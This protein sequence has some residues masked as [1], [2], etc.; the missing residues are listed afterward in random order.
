MKPGILVAVAGAAA[1]TSVAALS[2]PRAQEG[3][4]YLRVPVN[5]VKPD[6]S[7]LSKRDAFEVL[8]KNRDFFYSMDSKCLFDPQ[9]ASFFCRSTSHFPRHGSTRETHI[10]K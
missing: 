9:L 8:L 1:V 7:G 3:A 10:K 4:G 6:L 5:E 2:F